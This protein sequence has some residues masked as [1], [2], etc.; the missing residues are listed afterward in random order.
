M[1]K[2]LITTY[3]EGLPVPADFEF[4]KYEVDDHD[5][6]YATLTYEK[7]DGVALKVHTVERFEGMPLERIARKAWIANVLSKRSREEMIF[8]G[9]FLHLGKRIN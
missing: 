8:D 1:S 6:D 5:T 9:L 4:V 3:S 7:P 2:P